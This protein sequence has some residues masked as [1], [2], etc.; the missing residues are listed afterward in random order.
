MAILNSQRPSEINA[1]EPDATHLLAE[2]A[3]LRSIQEMLGHASLSTTQRYT[4][5]ATDQL[6]AVYDRAHP[7]AKSGKIPPTEKDGPAT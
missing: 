6:L 5:L 1:L 4:H 3:D 2:G 7:R